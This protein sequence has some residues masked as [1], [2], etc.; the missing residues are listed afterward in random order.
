MKNLLLI[1]LAAFMLAACGKENSGPNHGKMEFDGKSFSFS[2]IE[3]YKLVNLRYTTLSYIAPDRTDLTLAIDI[4]PRE[5]WEFE[6]SATSQTPGVMVI[7]KNKLYTSGTYRYLDRR[8]YPARWL[9]GANPEE[10]REIFELT[11]Q[12]GTITGGHIKWMVDGAVARFEFELAFV[13]GKTAKGSGVVPLAEIL[14]D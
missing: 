1:L 5:S 6:L 12:E 3:Y 8:E 4:D 11:E 10:G 2:H 13:D 9:L 7:Y 14:T